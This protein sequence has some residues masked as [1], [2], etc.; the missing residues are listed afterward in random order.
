[1]AAPGSGI[2]VYWTS[3]DSFVVDV[4]A[5]FLTTDQPYNAGGQDLGPTPVELFVVSL[6]ACIGFFAERYMRRHEIDADGLRVQ[7]RF[8]MAE[9]PARVSCID[10]HLALPAGFPPGRRRPVHRPQL[11]APAPPGAGRAGAG[12]SRRLRESESSGNT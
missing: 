10:I 1:M 11:D 7:C 5:H 6:G 9:H 8:Q 2:S 12:R 3:G 4:R